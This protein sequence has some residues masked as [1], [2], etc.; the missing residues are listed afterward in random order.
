LAIGSLERSVRL[1][2]LSKG[3]PVLGAGAPLM[4]SPKRQGG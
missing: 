2:V 3:Q 4:N 1:P